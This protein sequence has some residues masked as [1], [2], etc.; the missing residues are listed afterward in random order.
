[1]SC[2]G[3]IWYYEE[4]DVNWKECKHPEHTEDDELEECQYYYSKVDAWHNAHSSEGNN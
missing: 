2:E 3:C 1:M 4:K